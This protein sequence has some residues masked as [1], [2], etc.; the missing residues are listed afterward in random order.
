[1][2]KYTSLE[3]EILSCW[4]ITDEI[5]TVY[6]SIMNDDM[7]KDE[8]AN[9]LLGLQQLYNIKFN[10]MFEQYSK[11]LSKGLIQPLPD[12]HI[13]TLFQQHTDHGIL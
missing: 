4:C 5:G 13:A 9:I 11:M 6:E 12:D 8:I 3:D 10:R 1:M 2:S 7:S